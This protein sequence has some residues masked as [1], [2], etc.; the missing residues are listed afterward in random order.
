MRETSTIHQICDRV[1]RLLLRYEELQRTND[2][3]LKQV[4]ALRRERDQLH[5]RMD[6]AKARIDALLHRVPEP[7][8]PVQHSEGEKMQPKQPTQSD[9]G[10]GEN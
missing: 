8:K 1:D 5:A 2:L 9:T 7:P 4:D 10:K 3:L 6:T